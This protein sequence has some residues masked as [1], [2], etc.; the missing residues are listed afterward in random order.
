MTQTIASIPLD[1]IDPHPDQPRR[2]FD[3]A[4]LEE[5]AASIREHGVMQP[6]TVEA[7]GSDRYVIQLGE[8]RWR[9]A[10]IAGLAEIPA[11]VVPAKQ[12]SDRD[13]LI[14]ALVENLQREDLNPIDE[15]QAFQRL[16]EAGLSNTEIARR[17]GVSSHRIPAR[18][19]LLELDPEIQQFL[20]SG[21]LH[22]DPR[23]ARALLDIPDREVR[24]RYATEAARRRFSIKGILIG[25][26]RI[27]AVIE[28]QELEREKTPSLAFAVRR[29]AAEWNL[30]RQVE[31]DLGR[32][33][34]SWET[35]KLAA[36]ATCAACELRDV[37]SKQV[38]NTC[39]GVDVIANMIEIE[40]NRA[41]KKQARPAR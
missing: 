37:A 23:V 36:D 29:R 12:T 27:A 2:T 14:R 39:P 22:K 26:R 20:A 11:I 4:A 15:A 18:L 6:I 13:R 40:A 32:R 8:R 5:L 38:C 25:S 21:Q 28:A 24:I 10:Q 41:R 35:V 31:L 17:C 33:M 1:H 7:N 3:Q 30:I 16:T 34:P 19:I 9:A